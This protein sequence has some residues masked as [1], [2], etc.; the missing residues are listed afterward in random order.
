[1]DLG[2]K[3]K[4]ALVTGGIALEVLIFDRAGTLYVA[5]N[6]LDA[7]TTVDHHGDVEVRAQG[8]LL[9]SPSSLVFG[10]TPATRHKLYVVSSAFM[11]TLGLKPGT[12][13]PALLSGHVAVPGLGLP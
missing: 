13:E 4:C 1:M 12:P 8:G 5:V 10:A 11:R 7:V 9:D 2:L 3:G 6:G